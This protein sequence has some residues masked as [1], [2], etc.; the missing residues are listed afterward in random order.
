MGTPTACPFASRRI[1][2]TGAR[3]KARP[4]SCSITFTIPATTA[5]APPR[6]Y[7]PPCEGEEK[8]EEVVMV[9]EEAEEEEGEEAA[10]AEQA[11]VAEEDAVVGGWDVP[12]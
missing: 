4:P 5:A 12:A 10:K 6:G 2:P 11:E 9:L 1:A 8:R 7:A 3:T